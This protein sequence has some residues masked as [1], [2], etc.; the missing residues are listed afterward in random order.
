MWKK[1]LKF[2]LKKVSK[3]YWI[4]SYLV[5]ACVDVWLKWAVRID[6]HISAVTVQASNFNFVSKAPSRLT[7]AQ[8]ILS[9]RISAINYIL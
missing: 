1:I 7:L 3:K 2:S 8:N 4:R 9:G 5:I 6:E